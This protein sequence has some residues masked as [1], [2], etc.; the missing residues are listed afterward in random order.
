MRFVEISKLSQFIEATRDFIESNDVAGIYTDIDSKSVISLQ[1]EALLSDRDYLKEVTSLLN[2][3][4]SIIHHPHIANKSEDVILRVEQA[5][6]LGSEEFRQVIRDSKLWK[7]HGARMIPE[8]VHYR[9]QIDELRIYENRFIVFLIDAIERELTGYTAFYL[10]KL[11]TLK[12]DT[13]HLNAGE[14]GD[15]I[16]TVDRLKRKIQFIKGTYFY[17][18][19]SVGKALSGKIH[20]TNILTKD[21]LYRHC[22]KFYRTFIRYSD[23]TALCA[24]LRIY[25]VLCILKEL[26]KNGF[27]LDGLADKSDEVLK[28]RCGEFKIKFEIADEV[29]VIVRISVKDLPEASHLLVFGASGAKIPATAHNFKDFTTAEI[30]SLWELIPSDNEKS[31][32]CAPETSLIHFWLSSKITT[33][34]VDRRIYEKYCPI[35]ASRSIDSDGGI[36]RCRNCDSEYSF[37]GGTDTERVWFRK[38][39]R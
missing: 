7:R 25:Y 30:M 18:V 39:R 13:E 3:I 22:F 6:A 37:I 11:P 23:I 8:E 12:S 19:V 14:I 5:N 21:R 38:I 15:I 33:A 35:C 36:C 4:I 20:P 24:D 27:V 17:K 29:S 26:K 9:Q 2:V 10:T 1:S 34:S 28:L 32:L 16:L 31:R